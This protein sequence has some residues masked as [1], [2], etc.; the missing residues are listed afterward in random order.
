MPVKTE[1]KAAPS[2]LEL[3]PE[4]ADNNTRNVAARNAVVLPSTAPPVVQPKSAAPVTAREANLPVAVK[5]NETRTASGPPEAGI[6]QAPPASARVAENILPASKPLSAADKAEIVRQTADGL[7]T[8]P[9]PVKPGGTQQMSLQLHPKDWGSLQISV[10]VTTGQQAGAAKS[11]TAHIVAETPQVKAALQSQT[12]ALHQAL[13]ASG[14]NLDH[15]TV[16]VKPEEPKLTVIKPSAEAASAGLSSW[17][18][19]GNSAGQPGA[20]PAGAN[21]AGTSLG[22]SQAQAGSSQNGRQQQ[23]APAQAGRDEPEPDQL[24]RQVVPLRPV[25]GR[26]DTHA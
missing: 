4:N 3:E 14:L 23:P 16:S 21:S 2:A 11:V 6:S 10:S 19:Q 5:R 24:G 12:G 7:Q 26:I 20:S 15:L 1:G 25:T 8:M 9:L 22:S 13:R 17:Q 18:G